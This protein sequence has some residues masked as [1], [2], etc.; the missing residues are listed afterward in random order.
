MNLVKECSSKSTPLQLS[1]QLAGK[2]GSSKDQQTK[3]TLTTHKGLPH[4]CSQSQDRMFCSKSQM[5]CMLLF[6]YR[7]IKYQNKNDL[8]KL[9]KAGPLR[10]KLMLFIRSMSRKS[11]A[12][13]SFQ[14]MAVYTESYYEYIASAFG[15]AS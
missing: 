2:S 9:D 7:N 13:G 5:S 14:L 3:W 4:A 8:R 1:Q 10:T 15:N 6:V 11:D 12:V